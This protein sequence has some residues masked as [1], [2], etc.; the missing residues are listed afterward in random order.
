MLPIQLLAVLTLVGYALYR[1]SR[2]KE[3]ANRGRFTLAI[4]YAAIGLALGVHVDRAP[5][6]LALLTVSLLAS[7][8]IGVLRGRRT[9]VWRDEADRVFSRGTVV[10]IGLFL[11]LIA[12]KVMLGSIAYLTHTPYDSGLG[13]ILVLI[14]AML[15]VQAEIIRRRVLELSTPRSPVPGPAARQPLLAHP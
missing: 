1:Q 8:G 9:R 3:I 11:G 7:L 2:A 5:L 14:G 12:F 13:G 10:T 6:S 4:T 15:A